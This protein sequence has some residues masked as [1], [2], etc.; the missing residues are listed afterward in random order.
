MKTT[1]NA[2]QQ[3]SNLKTFSSQRGFFTAAIG[4]ALTALFASTAGIMATAHEQE[5][6]IEGHAMQQIDSQT[7]HSQSNG[8]CAD[9]KAE[10][11]Q[12]VTKRRGTRVYGRTGRTEKVACS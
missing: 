10:R 11:I 7:V 6:N 1:Y 3:A 5:G 8:H 2:I 12:I 4:L 9:G